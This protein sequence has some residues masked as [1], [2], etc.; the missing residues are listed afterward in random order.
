MS[1]KKSGLFSVLLTA[2]LMSISSQADTQRQYLDCARPDTF[3]KVIINIY[4]D[5]STGTLFFSAD[6][7]SGEN[8]GVIKV[9]KT[10]N[11]PAHG[12]E[13]TIYRGENSMSLFEVV[14]PTKE[15]FVVSDR[16]TIRVFGMTKDGSVTGGGEMTCFSR[17]YN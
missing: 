9:L 7:E 5:G 1:L 12:F 15:L 14:I 3:D 11:E 16:I 10:V 2:F 4:G 8:S 6:A 13:T 17:V